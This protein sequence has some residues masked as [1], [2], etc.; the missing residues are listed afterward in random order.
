MS[1]KN[2][3]NIKECKN[4]KKLTMITAYDAA[5]AKIAER[6]GIDMILVGDSLG[7]TVQGNADTNSVTLD[8]IVYHTKIVA[9]NAPNTFTVADM[10]F[11]SYEISPGQALE[12]AGRIFR[13]TGAR[14]VK[15]EG[16]KNILPQIKA[17][18]D[19]GIPVMG[20]IGLTPQRA[21]MFGG[22]KAQAR[23]AQGAAQL[24]E[25]A[26]LLENAGCFAI[27]L[28]AVPAAVAQCITQKLTVPTISCGGGKFCDG[29]VLVIH[30][31]LGLSDF[32]PRFVKKYANL[33]DLAVQAVQ[34]YINDVEKNAFPA[35]EHSF[36]I[37][38]NEWELFKKSL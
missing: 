27:V 11:M 37:D 7:M 1:K 20:H 2:I 35:E 26:L 21:A 30:D 15:M 36:S 22:F 14:A 29:Q 6:A 28:E 8:D 32:T 12:N 19:A 4:R 16:G 34:D 18:T 9:K 10:P 38:E 17:L 31:M 3:L 23:T 13:E 24:L 33:G 25:D 5:T